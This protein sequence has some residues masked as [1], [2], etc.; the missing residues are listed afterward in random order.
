MLTYQNVV[1]KHI[2]LQATLSNIW[3]Y[4]RNDQRYLVAG[5]KSQGSKTF[6]VWKVSKCGV[7]SCPYFLVFNPNTGKYGP[8]KTP[9]WNTFHEVFDEEQYYYYLKNLLVFY[10]LFYLAKI[11]F[12][13]F[14][15]QKTKASQVQGIYHLDHEIIWI[16]KLIIN[17]IT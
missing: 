4:V 7:F 11:C 15:K 8:E 6:T 9:Y 2:K 13:C 14:G 10:S 3:R 16:I 5:S 12:Y 1:G 17:V